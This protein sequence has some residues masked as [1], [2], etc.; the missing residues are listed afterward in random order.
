M[1]DKKLI[2]EGEDFPGLFDVIKKSGYIVAG[3]TVKEGAIVYDYLSS[4]SSL[5]RGLTDEQDA[6]FYRLKKAENSKY[7]DYT[8]GP[9]SW[10]KFLFPPEV[11]LWS[12][13][14]NGKGVVFGY[15]KDRP[16]KTAFIGVRACE[17]AAI[18]IQDVILTGGDYVDPIYRRRREKALIV[19]V[20][21]TRAGG[22][23]FCASMGAGPKVEGGYD[24]ALTEI[25]EDGRHYFVIEAGTETGKEILKGLRLT[26][27]S[28]NDEAAALSAIEDVSN[29]MGRSLDTGG[30]KE[31]LQA[32]YEHTRWEDVASRCLSCA[33][34]TIVCP[35]CFCGN[36]E[37]VTDLSGRATERWRRWDSC[38]SREYS[39]IHGGSVRA[40]TMARYR[41]WLMHKL[42]NWVDQF[43]SFGCVGCGRCITWCP[44]GIDITE[45]ASAVRKSRLSVVDT[46]S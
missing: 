13:S 32:S 23:C 46:V 27:A 31:I 21:C 36:I 1:V 10:K 20:N 39:F 22:T 14:L 37:D 44:A 18:E 25:Q 15:D 41:H 3:P 12:A 5:P 4:V 28:S 38:F 34:C 26:T 7:F 43:G 17:L 11:K 33:N 19:A 16:R 9:Q 40:S 35:T 8:L 30:L 2:L 29:R 45:E 6:A 42:A 24:I